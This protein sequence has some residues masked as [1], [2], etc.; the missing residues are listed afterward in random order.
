MRFEQF[1]SDDAG[2]TASSQNH[3]KK[4]PYCGRYMMYWLS[5][6]VMKD[7]NPKTWNAF[8]KWC[9]NEVWAVEACAWNKGPLV[10]IN[11]ARVGHAMGRTT[12]GDNGEVVC[13]IHGK[14]ANA[15]EQGTG[16]IIW[17]STV[18]HELVHWAR[19]KQNIPD[20]PSVEPGKAFEVDAYGQDVDLKTPWR[21]G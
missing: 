18:L 13:H 17:E 8:V 16:W 19:F 4:F 2:P 21:R 11:S 14:A 6:K 3:A 5:P 7:K 10:Q 12:A 20:D 15:Y 1:D 9:G